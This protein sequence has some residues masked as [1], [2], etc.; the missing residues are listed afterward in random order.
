MS[1]KSFLTNKGYDFDNC[2]ST[3]YWSIKTRI[4]YI[5]RKILICSIIYYELNSNMM[6]DNDYNIIS[7][8]LTEMINNTDI[9]VVKKTK[10]YY[11]FKDFSSSTGF[12][13]Y[14]KLNKQDKQYLYDL[15]CMLV[16][17][18]MNSNC[19]IKSDKSKR[20]KKK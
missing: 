15:S 18:G 8:Q 11:V 7:Q 10:Y 14:S 12:D 20:S 4:E 16:N 19:K 5:Q 13:L 2:I 6:T 1:N 17:R 3:K 9:S